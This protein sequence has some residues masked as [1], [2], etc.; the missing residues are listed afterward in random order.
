M[1][2]EKRSTYLVALGHRT[3]IARD[4][5]PTPERRIDFH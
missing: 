5:W 3:A 1:A 4:T 2:N